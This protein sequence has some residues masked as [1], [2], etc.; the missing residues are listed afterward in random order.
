MRS[1][2]LIVDAHYDDFPHTKAA[3]GGKYYLVG[4]IFLFLLAQ[5]T[6]CS[7]EYKCYNMV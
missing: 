1:T 2:A 4:N 7:T 6:G 3:L 5:A